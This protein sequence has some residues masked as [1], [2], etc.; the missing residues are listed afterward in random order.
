[1]KRIQTNLRHAF[2]VH[3]EPLDVKVASRK[4]PFKTN[5]DTVSNYKL[6]CKENPQKKGSED[7]ILDV[8]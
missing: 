1:M 4:G 6:I 7:F 2:P 5:S 3:F 8:M